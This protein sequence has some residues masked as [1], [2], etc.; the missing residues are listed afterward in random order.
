MTFTIAAFFHLQHAF[1]SSHCIFLLDI[2]EQFINAY[3]LYFNEFNLQIV[4]TIEIKF[5]FN[6]DIM[7]I[8]SSHGQTY[9]FHSITLN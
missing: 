6:N 5:Q 2:K 1:L 3:F 8:P 7:V 4:E 9:V